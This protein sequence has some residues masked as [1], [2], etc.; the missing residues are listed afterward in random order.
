MDDGRWWRRRPLG[1][2][3]PLVQ[4]AGW[5]FALR[6]HAL[7]TAW[8]SVDGSYLAERNEHDF[9][10][11]GVDWSFVPPEASG[12]A[13][14]A[15]GGEPGPD[16]VT[17][18][19]ELRLLLQPFAREPLELR[20]SGEFPDESSGETIEVRWDGEALPLRR[21]PGALRVLLPAGRAHRVGELVLRGP[22]RL[23]RLQVGATSR[24]WFQPRSR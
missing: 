2:G 13:L 20:L 10:L 16:G 18:R 7:A 22:A 6:H 11:S 5:L 21:E 14:I 15:A 9:A 19:G 23:V 12:L 3:S 17:V 8:E 24:Y 4:P 1:L